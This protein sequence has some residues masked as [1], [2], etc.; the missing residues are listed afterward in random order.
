MWS[1]RATRWP[2]G[3]TQRISALWDR[4]KGIIAAGI[5]LVTCPCH[6]IVT[7]PILLSLTAGTTVGAFLRRNVW[8]MV[9]GSTLLFV[10]SLT[11]AYRWW[12]AGTGACRVPGGDEAS[13]PTGGRQS[14]RRQEVASP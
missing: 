14:K 9:A 8:L 7:L 6:L 10:S 2:E 3:R 1:T 12:G 4:V 11:L 5:A 13:S